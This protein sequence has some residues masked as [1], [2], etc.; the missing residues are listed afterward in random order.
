MQV[1]TSRAHKNAVYTAMLDRIDCGPFDGG[2]V[3]FAMALQAVLGGEVQVITGDLRWHPRQTNWVKGA[4]H[5]VLKLPDG[6]LMDALGPGTHDEVVSR[7]LREEITP[8]ALMKFT[9]VRELR[10]DDLPEAPR[11][12]ALIEKLASLLS[13]L[14][15]APEARESVKP[16]MDDRRAPN[17]RR[18]RDNFTDWFDDSKIVDVDGDP[19]VVYHGTNQDFSSF[20][21]EADPRSYES[22]RGKF[23]FTSNPQH[24]SGYAEDDGMG[25]NAGAPN[26]IAAYVAI[27]NPFVI[28]NSDDPT[29]DWDR[30]GDLYSALAEEQGRDGIVIQTE[31]GSEKLVI[32]FRPE[33]IK[34]AIGNS[35][36]YDPANA[37]I[38]DAALEPTAR[39][40]RGMA[41]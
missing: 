27:Q 28:D 17:G 36:N 8:P 22:D 25:K 23:F 40:T 7:F 32:A 30:N 20:D 5:A 15:Q 4:Q 39:L 21:P 9:G 18:V 29:N 11:D 37:C 19:L 31:D 14:S 26:V 33:Q 6:R 1:F 16:W 10:P 12:A 24:A 38:S 35:G 3:S 34:S 41:P 2:C 13:H